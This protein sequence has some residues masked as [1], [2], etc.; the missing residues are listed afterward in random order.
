MTAFLVVAPLASL[1]SRPAAAGDPLLR[2]GIHRTQRGRYLMDVCSHDKAPF[3][4]TE[5][6]LPDDWN[7]LLPVPKRAAAAT[8]TGMAPADIVGA[9][10]IPD[11]AKANGKVVAVLD[12]P[13]SNAL[14]DMNAY[15][16]QFGIAPLP[17]CSGGK[18]TGSLPA[19]FAQVAQ[20]GGPSSGT[21][22]SDDTETAL[23]VEMISAACP[24]CSILLVELADPADLNQATTTA[25]TLGAVATSISLGGPEGTDPTNSQMYTD[26]T[27]YTVA[28][29]LV[30][31]ASGDFA[32]DQGNNSNQSPS[33][34]ASS[35]DVMAV[36]GTTLFAL[37]SGKYDE[38]VWDDGSFT[39]QD[40]T[41]S[42][43]STEFS[44]LSWQS[45]AL[46]GTG[47]SMRATADLS[48]AASFSTGGEETAIAIYQHGWE[49]VE[50]TSASSPLMA[51]LLT[52]VGLAATIAN[53]LS[54]EYTHASAFNDLGS[55][56]Y[57]ADSSGSTTDAPG[58]TSCG[59]LCDLATGW[60]GPSG[61]G[62]PIGTTL[63]AL[64]GGGSSSS[65]SGSG[66]TSG[67]S[68]GSTSGSGSGS[69][70]GS[71][72]GSTSGSSSGSTS[73]SGS[74]SESGSSSGSSGGSSSSGSASGSSSGSTSGSSG[75]ST[76]GSSGASTSGSSSG[77]TSGSSSGSPASGSSGSTSGSSGASGSSGSASGSGSS[78][79]SSSSGS[80]GSHGGVGA[81]SGGG[82]S[83]EEDAGSNEALGVTSPGGSTGGCSA[84]PAGTGTSG[85]GSAV[86]AALGL[87]AIGSR[88]R[89]R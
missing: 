67:S 25:Q 21:D 26:E 17:A 9:Y 52:R 76:S 29:H 39:G 48:A 57:P 49:N 22:S 12:S 61:V 73:G 65:G 19:C 34:P 28:G 80:A 3:C 33:F 69:T 1:P 4:L 70:S 20:D 45:T 58:G 31:A 54:W 59:K 71:S 35:P 44:G 51:G 64:A 50:G 24:D 74:G 68:S 47:C 79:G 88:R 83:D 63:A 86:L 23:D 41:T 2:K 37:G 14:A 55:S 18:P 82:G 87:V 46:A 75:T 85:G 11:S 13:D 36:G 56:S 77:S 53:D 84:A 27:G 6:L 66:S 32:Y 16:T 62:T 78:A 10:K 5:R 72:S 30:L 89:R 15:R 40:V 43:C 42:G 38:A 60:D 7:P 8:P 81:S